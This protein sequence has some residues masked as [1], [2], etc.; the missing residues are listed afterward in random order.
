LK[1]IL[2]PAGFKI[3]NI[4]YSID[5]K[6][7]QDLSLSLKYQELQTISNKKRR[8]AGNPKLIGMIVL[9]SRELAKNSP[10][11]KSFSA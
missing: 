8:S 9:I 6:G 4:D 3:S 2:I 7:F 10:I 11:G 5:I 1:E